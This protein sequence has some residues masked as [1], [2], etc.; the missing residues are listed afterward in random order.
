MEALLDS[1]ARPASLFLHRN[2]KALATCGARRG[3]IHGETDRPSPVVRRLGAPLYPQTRCYCNVF[4][5]R[6]TMYLNCLY[7][8]FLLT[9]SWSILE[10][11]EPVLI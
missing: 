2:I 10:I 3:E 1:K 7:D 4:L 11:W 5:D 9:I 8:I 6:A